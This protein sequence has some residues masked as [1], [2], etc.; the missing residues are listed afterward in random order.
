[1][2]N[3]IS[4]RKANAND[5]S[6]LYQLD[7][8]SDEN[9]H[10]KLSFFNYQD[11]IKI[12]IIAN[13]IVGFVVYQTTDVVEIFRITTRHNFKNQG[14]A[15]ALIEALKQL[16]KSIILELREGNLKAFQLYQKLGFEQ[17]Y[18][19]EKYYSNGENAKIMQFSIVN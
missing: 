6:V 10:W 1:M 11:L 4:F 16:N 2:I 17:I 3:N 19:R 7:R 9:F 15:T 5:L 18:R 13:Q 14:V 12:A 8:L